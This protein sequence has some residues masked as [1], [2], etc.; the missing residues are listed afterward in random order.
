MVKYNNYYGQSVAIIGKAEKG[1]KLNPYLID[2]E[3]KALDIFGSGDLI[4]AYYEVSSVGAEYIYM[5]RL[6]YDNEVELY[7]NLAE[8]YDILNNLRDIDVILPL[9]INLDDY[10]IDY[11]DLFN[12]RQEFVYQD[13]NMFSP[14]KLIE[15]VNHIKVNGSKTEKYSLNEYETGIYESF[16]I[17]FELVEDDV[18]RINYNTIQSVPFEYELLAFKGGHIKDSIKLSDNISPADDNIQITDKAINNYFV[19]EETDDVNYVARCDK[20]YIQVYTNKEKGNVYAKFDYEKYKQEE[21]ETKYY[22]KKLAK[23]C[24]RLHAVG[25]LKPSSYDYDDLNKS[26][27]QMKD[28]LNTSSNDYGKYIVTTP[29]TCYYGN[30]SNEYS[31][32]YITAMAGLMGT[33]PTNNSLTH[34]KTPNVK[35]IKSKYSN[36]KIKNLTE[37]GYTVLYSSVRN[38]IVPYKAITL[39]QD[40][41]PYRS[42]KNMRVVNE[43]L[44]RTKMIADLFIGKSMSK[45][46]Y[47]L[48]KKL[49]SLY[50]SLVDNNKLK[51]FEYSLET[52]KAGYIKI[53]LA[54][55]L[56]NEL[57]TINTGVI[58]RA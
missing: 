19:V 27:Y 14:D 4:D 20:P 35:E 39:A 23:S 21:T 1:E 44:S 33:L 3:D 15:S 34:Q 13:D 18:V 7:K 41:S 46:N 25:I 37:L 57:Q 51:D 5:I 58:A 50:N 12:Y 2:S 16:S 55:Q 8:I 53:D 36:S 49:D 31:S 42:L 17:D 6:D 29:S 56:Y 22:A 38:G 11:P 28:V 30:G 10:I 9:D 45:I 40:N 52:V 43:L 48:S 24:S 32:S 47:N 54:L 26:I